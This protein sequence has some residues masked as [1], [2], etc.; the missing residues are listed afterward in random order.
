M[1]KYHYIG[2]HRYS[3]ISYK[4]YNGSETI[5]KYLEMIQLLDRQFVE[6]FKTCIGLS[7]TSEF[8]FISTIRDLYW[9]TQVK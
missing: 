3:E 2:V 5:D 1:I 8:S 7:Y 6:L 9:F 4:T